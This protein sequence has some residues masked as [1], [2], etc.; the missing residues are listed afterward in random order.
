MAQFDLPLVGG[1]VHFPNMEFMADIINF[2]LV[3]L[4]GKPLI[5]LGLR[6]STGEF[7]LPSGTQ[8]ADSLPL[9]LDAVGKGFAISSVMNVKVSNPTDL[10]PDMVRKL[11][12][13]FKEDMHAADG[14]L[15]QWCARNFY[16]DVENTEM[17]IP[18]FQNGV[19]LSRKFVNQ[20]HP[21]NLD[22]EKTTGIRTIEFGLFVKWT[23]S[24]SIGVSIAAEAD[25]V[26]KSNPDKSIREENVTIVGKAEFRMSLSLSGFSLEI[27]LAASLK[28]ESQ[29]WLN[30]MKQIPNLGIIFPIGLGIGFTVTFAPPFIVPSMFEIEGGIVGCAGK[31]VV[32]IGNLKDAKAVGVKPTAPPPAPA[33]PPGEEDE[34]ADVKDVIESSF[35]AEI[36]K[37][38]CANAPYGTEPLVIK[39][40]LVIKQDGVAFLLILRNFSMGRLMLTLLGKWPTAV[41]IITAVKPILDAVW[42]DK[43]DI[44]FSSGGPVTTYA[45]TTIKGGLALDIVNLKFLDGLVTVRRCMFNM[46]M[47]PPLI[48]A[49]IFI[50]LIRLEVGGVLL[51]EITGLGR[52]SM[53]DAHAKKAK[54]EQERAKMN[55]LAASSGRWAWTW[56][57]GARTGTPACAASRGASR[58]GGR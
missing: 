31:L 22:D 56:R 46:V 26:I 2:P 49:H 37:M 43:F 52:D 28:A 42:A 13:K 9:K 53:A 41:K 48:E 11:M 23:G 19:S 18:V 12:E 36:N 33:S 21:Y 34:D 5:K 6:F 8:M 25:F 54:A 17:Q 51:L 10:F 7:S 39:L 24:L 16:A 40:A 15:F 55:M 32:P 1:K 29:I 4:I 38:K 47:F 50:D 20:T 27:M 3:A 57:A 35:M 45:G 44:S 14:N 58:A 30:P